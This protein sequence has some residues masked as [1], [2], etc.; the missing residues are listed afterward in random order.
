[1]ARS[2]CDRGI[3]C[4]DAAGACPESTMPGT[5]AGPDPE[6]RRRGTDPVTARSRIALRWALGGLA[7]HLLIAVAFLA[8]YDFNP[9]FFVHFGENGSVMGLAR[10][11]FGSDLLVPHVDGQDGQAFWVLARDPLLLHGTTV[12]APN[13]DRPGYRAQRVAYPALAAPWRLGGE[14]SLL[15]GLLVTNLIVVFVGGFVAVLLA[16]DLGAPVRAGLAFALSPAVMLSTIL[17]VADAL[18]LAALLAAL[19]ALRRDRPA[20][21]VGAAT[22]A[23]LAKEVTLLG[24]AG[25]A[26]LSPSLPSRT[27]WKLVGVPTAAMLGWGIYARWRL[28]WPPADVQE[29]GFPLYG[30]LDA[31]RRGWLPVGNWADAVIAFALIPIGVLV[32]ARWWSRRSLLLSAAVPFVLFVPFLSAQVLDL[33]F[34]S[35]RVIGP[36]VTLLWLDMY[37]PAAARTVSD[38]NRTE[39]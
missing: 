19:L 7:V 17:D 28:G 23:V 2:G 30:Y 39:A 9:Q 37:V 10:T 13:L 5:V 4:R 21:G 38:T 1:M 27:R 24:V 12:I 26:L 8:R 16:L 32:I 33:L 22:L 20:W 6:C 31:Y 3:A 18:A 15:W 34:N 11:V 14:Y 29:F 25:A 35:L 36:A